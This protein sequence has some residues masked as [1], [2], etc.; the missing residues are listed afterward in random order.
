MREVRAGDRL[1]AYRIERRLGRGGMGVVYLA[2]DLRLARRV[3]IKVISPDVSSD[4]VFHERILHEARLAASIDHPHVIPVYEVGDEDGLLFLAMRY[5]DGADLRE[6]L[7]REG[8]LEP[9]RALRLAEQVASALDAAHGRG[10]IHR[11]VKPANILVAGVQPDEHVYLCDFGLTKE[12]GTASGLSVTGELL[13]TIDYMAPEQI[14]GEEPDRRADVYALGC[15]L[16]QMVLGEPP[17]LGTD[18]AVMLAHLNNEPPVIHEGPA[19]ALADPIA[20]ALA[21]DPGERYPTAGAFI[22]DAA[23]AL[24]RPAPRRRKRRGTRTSRR[25]AIG[26]SVMTTLAVGVSVAVVLGE[27]NHAAGGTGTTTTSLETTRKV[28]T[29]SPRGLPPG[30]TSAIAYP[31]NAH[32]DIVSP[33]GKLVRTLKTKKP[34]A[35][36]SWSPD[37]TQLVGARGGHIWVIDAD[38][39]GRQ[40]EV[41][42]GPATDAYPVWSPDGSTILFTRQPSGSQQTSIYMITPGSPPKRVTTPT[43]FPPLS[44][45][46]PGWSP[47]GRQIVAEGFHGKRTIGQGTLYVMNRDGSDLHAI[48][49]N[50]IAVDPSWSPDGRHIAFRVEH[51][52]AEDDIYIAGADGSHPHKIIHNGEAP[53]WSPDGTRIA[54]ERFGSF[55]KNDNSS[56]CKGCFYMWNGELVVANADGTHPHVITRDLTGDQFE[57]ASWSASGA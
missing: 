4:P 20:R 14:R 21:K 36:V 28:V 12:Q 3:A 13:G 18:V 6:L 7:L 52:H 19:A 33:T 22:S 27:R 17:Y 8:T 16:Y 44:F 9:R 5:V 29:A 57:D 24:G 15:V 40:T 45:A 39:V 53:A 54:F 47:D 38:A 49:R 32:I 41:T 23:D 46:D 48:T 10:L 55:F 43:G 51:V 1:A 37:G 11:D 30:V 42:D 50:L 34:Y 2:E 26:L 35:S 56:G 25:A 31:V